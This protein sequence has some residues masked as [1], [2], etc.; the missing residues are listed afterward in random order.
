LGNLAALRSPLG[1]R[2]CIGRWHSAV[3]LPMVVAAKSF[4]TRRKDISQSIVNAGY[5]SQGSTAFDRIMLSPK[6]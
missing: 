2:A 4:T 6:G 1:D 3:P 5:F